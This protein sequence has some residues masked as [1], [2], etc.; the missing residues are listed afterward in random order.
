M[1]VGQDPATKQWFLANAVAPSGQSVALY[2]NS[3]LVG[4]ANAGA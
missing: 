1:W 3:S 4:T 2:L